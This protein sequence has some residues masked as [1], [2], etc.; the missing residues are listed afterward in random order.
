MTVTVT[1]HIQEGENQLSRTFG[2][3]DSALAD[4]RFKFNPSGLEDV[5]ILKALAAAM[6]CETMNRVSSKAPREAAHS[7]TQVQDASMWAV[8]GATVGL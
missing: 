1:V 8:A 7:R 6:I 4:V 5:T 3:S 2:V